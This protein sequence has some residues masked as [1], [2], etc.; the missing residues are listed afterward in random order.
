MPP[1]L[2]KK[3]QMEIIAYAFCNIYQQTTE[4]SL[5]VSCN[6]TFQGQPESDDRPV[7]Q[8]II[9]SLSGRPY[10]MFQKRDGKQG[11]KDT[12]IDG[13]GLE[14]IYFSTRTLMKKGL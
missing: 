2:P 11:R 9:H 6:G 8:I 13:L 4:G 12:R 14:W 5:Q 10:S 3:I 7:Y 1:S